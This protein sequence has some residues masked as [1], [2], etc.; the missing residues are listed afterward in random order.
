[1]NAGDRMKKLSDLLTLH[2]ELDE[3]FLAHQRRLLHF[4]FNGAFSILDEYESFLLSH[5][6]DEEKILLP[7]YKSRGSQTPCGNAQLFL[8]E[9][10]RM[11]EWV[12]FFK[13][14]ITKLAADA[15]PEGDLIRLLDRQSFFK[16]LCSHHD[17]READFL[18]FELDRITSDSEKADLLRQVTCSRLMLNIA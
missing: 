13:Q 8:K 5:M 16:R 2:V 1:M 4:D 9:H 10:S 11:R 3:M 17:R 6:N 14:Q 12:T 7:I 15:T 18:Y